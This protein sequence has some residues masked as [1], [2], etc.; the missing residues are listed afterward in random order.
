MSVLDAS[1]LLALL[2]EEPGAARVEEAL[3]RP[4]AMSAVNWAEVLAHNVADSGLLRAVTSGATPVLSI[5]P[6]DDHQARETA[7]IKAAT[8]GV[9]LSLADRACLALGR[10]RNAPVLTADRAWRSLKLKVKVVVVR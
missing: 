2:N 5:V 10:L 6:F 8:A 9:Q 7:R 1:A 3:S 4:C